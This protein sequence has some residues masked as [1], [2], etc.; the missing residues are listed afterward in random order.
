MET[1][2]G[3]FCTVTAKYHPNMGS[4]RRRPAS[5]SVARR[6]ARPPNDCCGNGPP[7]GTIMYFRAL[8]ES[9]RAVSESYR[10]DTQ[11]LRS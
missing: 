11:A 4:A 10:P 1:G 5:S 6:M 9:P 7:T 8:V 2:S 3:L